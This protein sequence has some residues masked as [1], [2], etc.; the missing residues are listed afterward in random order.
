MTETVEHSP[1]LSMLMAG[2]AQGSLSRQEFE[3]R[4]HPEDIDRCE[5]RWKRTS[6]SELRSGALELRA[7]V[8]GQYHWFE[9][10]AQAV[11]D[12]AGRPV[13][14]VGSST[15]IDGRKLQEARLDFLAYYDELTGLPNRRLLT[16]RLSQQLAIS[17]EKQLKCAVVLVDIERFR[18]INETLGRRAGDEA[19][20]EITTRLRS[21]IEANWTISRYASNTFAIALGSLESESAVAQ[22]IEQ[23]LALLG[24]SA[25]VSG[26]NCAC[27]RASAWRCSP[28]TAKTATPCWPT[29]KPHSRSAKPGRSATYFTRPR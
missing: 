19:L 25:V 17:A 10:N 15:D 7:M 6:P 20:I 9:I 18:Q 21:I 29:Q 23:A 8:G 11:L 14:L 12:S 1:S 2:D 13:R 4:V 16:D 28:P 22:W 5:L 24:Q 27:R 26:T 3:A